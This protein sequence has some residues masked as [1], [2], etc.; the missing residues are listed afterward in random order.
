[1]NKDQ[2]TYQTLIDKVVGLSV[3]WIDRLE[4]AVTESTVFEYTKQ[5]LRQHF[6]ELTGAEFLRIERY[7]NDN[8]LLL[9]DRDTDM[10]MA[11]YDSLWNII[12]IE[13]S[14]LYA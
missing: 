10:F 2:Q 6:E 7:L 11:V 9:D 12:E 8:D 14:K 1:M 5:V 3:T 13:L 4:H